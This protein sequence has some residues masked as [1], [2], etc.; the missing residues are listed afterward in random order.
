VF[1]F[2][3]LRDKA[4]NPTYIHLHNLWGVSVFKL[5]LF[6]S[7]ASTSFG[8][9]PDLPVMHPAQQ[10]QRGDGWDEAL[11]EVPDQIRVAK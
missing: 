3:G 5:L 4:A 9:F 10:S 2:V 8:N 7:L 1:G 11:G 6:D